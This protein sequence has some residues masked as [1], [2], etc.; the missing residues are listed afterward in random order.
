MTPETKVLTTVAV[1][2]ASI[3]LISYASGSSCQ[4]SQN[5]ISEEQRAWD[6]LPIDY[7][8]E[9]EFLNSNLIYD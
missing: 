3:G 4:L 6:N 2:I 5:T 1:L 9:E 8:P 7:T